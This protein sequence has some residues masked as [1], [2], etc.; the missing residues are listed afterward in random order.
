MGLFGCGQ[1]TADVEAATALARLGDSAI[2]EIEKAL[3]AMENRGGPRGYGS[4]WVQLAY[5]RI[6]GPSAYPR[7]R[8]LEDDSKEAF[9]RDNLD[10]AIALSLALTSYVSNSRLPIRNISCTRGPEPRDAVDQLILG[11]E[12]NDRSWLERSLGPRART[13]LKA[14][15]QGKTWAAMRSE[16]W[17]AKP[18]DRVAVGYRF[19]IP[20]HWS[21]PAHTLEQQPASRD[22]T[23]ISLKDE[24][25]IDTVLTDSSGTDCGTRPVALLKSRTSAVGREKYLIDNS[26][27]GDLLRLI[28]SCAARASERP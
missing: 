14:L 25:N 26:N 11:W 12:R 13:A 3:N 22:N 10:S 8:R 28:S 4:M 16:L 9:E 1:V 21:E 7:L 18:D 15:L 2:P 6:K 5:A 23:R 24:F 19:N 27:L 20:G 17:S